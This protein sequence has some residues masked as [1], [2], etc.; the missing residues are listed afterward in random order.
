MSA[1]DFP[2]LRFSD[3]AATVALPSSFLPTL[4]GAGLAD[5]VTAETTPT[6]QTGAVNIQGCKQLDIFVDVTTSAAASKIF[7]KVRFS[8]KE[9]PLVTSPTDWGFIQ[10]DNID[11]ATGMSSVR[12]YVIEIDIASVNGIANV[13]PRYY[14]FRIQQISGRHASAI[15]WTNGANVEAE[16]LF[17]RQG[18][19]M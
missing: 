7:L 15:V 10:I 3:V 17:Q 19:S 8:G 2:R 18:G 5:A 1:S 4:G 6:C 9:Q 16:I 13:A 14:C 12:E 11:P